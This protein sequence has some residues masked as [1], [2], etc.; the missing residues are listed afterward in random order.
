MAENIKAALQRCRRSAY[1]VATAT[2]HA[3]NWLYRVINQ[4][5]GIL[6]PTL[7]EVA[8]ELG[9]TV[10]SLVD[11]PNADP[12]NEKRVADPN[13]LASDEQDL[14][15]AKPIIVH[16]LA[17]AAGSGALDLDESIKTH[18]YFRSEW[19]SKMG[20]HADRCRIIG[21]M[22]ESMEPTL[23]DGC[24]ILVDLNRTTILDG[25]I[26]IVRAEDGLI[27][28]RAGKTER[29]RWLMVSDHPD[30]EPVTWPQN[31]VVRGEVKWMAR[32][33]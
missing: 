6:I 4:D 21:V 2:G 22:G 25:H 31:A 28:K 1:S 14:P 9:V 11:P 29:G 7:R 8:S 13:A 17:T 24:V 30:W 12:A 18:A 10:G 26:Y 15:G 5:A 32:E 3:P 23:P 16:R 27:V 33:L 20:L 19:L